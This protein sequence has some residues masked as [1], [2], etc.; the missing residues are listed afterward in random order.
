MPKVYANTLQ[1]KEGVI[2][3]VIDKLAAVM[4]IDS[5]PEEVVSAVSD[6]LLTIKQ[7]PDFERI[8]VYPLDRILADHKAVDI[9]RNLCLCLSGEAPQGTLEIVIVQLNHALTNLQ[10]FLR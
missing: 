8:K 4:V 9:E 2:T 3:D 6:A 7:Y 10:S 1:H 5:D